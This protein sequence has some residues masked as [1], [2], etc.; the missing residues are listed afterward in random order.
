[1]PIQD[2]PH[3]YNWDNLSLTI[4]EAYQLISQQFV[5]EENG[6]RY[7]ITDIFFD[8]LS[9]QVVGRREIISPSGRAAPDPRD[10]GESFAVAY[11]RDRVQACQLPSVRRPSLNDIR[12][13]AFRLAVTEELER[14]QQFNILSASQI[15]C[16]PDEHGHYYYY[17]S[18]TEAQ[19]GL[20]QLALIIPS[21]D[22]VL[23]DA[24]LYQSHE[25]VGH[26]KRDKT[27][28]VL[29]RYVW[30]QGMSAA[31]RKYVQ[32]CPECIRRGSS[33]DRAIASFP[34]LVHGLVTHRWQRLSIDLQG[35]FPVSHSGNEYL[36]VAMDHFTK[37]AIATAIEDKDARTIADF[38]VTEIVLRF[39]AP[40]VILT[41]RGTEFCNQLNLWLC[42]ALGVHHAKTASYNPASNGQVE[43]FNQT[44]ANCL[45]KRCSDASHKDWDK[46]VAA[47]VS[48]SNICINRTTGYT[49]Y[50]L[51]YGEECRLP[52]DHSLPMTHFKGPRALDY[53]H[54]SEQLTAILS[55]AHSSTLSHQVA[56]QSLY[57]RPRKVEELPATFQQPNA[58]GSRLPRSFRQGDWVMLWC[59]HVHAGNAKKLVKMWDGPFQVQSVINP[60]S[61]RIRIM[62]RSR[63]VHVNRLKQY[64]GPLP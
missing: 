40:D 18:F 34:V 62:Q 60:V 23:Q 47:C 54:Y 51:V 28:N 42:E 56:S 16:I 52:L 29:S 38:I 55:S 44:I 5:D 36:C 30:W 13:E 22:K 46:H 24:L 21:T 25:A 50:F 64:Y 39:G 45:A 11:L 19:N 3:L 35:P 37:F 9:Q 63:I 59:P 49:P 33:T 43:R 4:P 26:H 14:L 20:E 2:M 32:A 61:Y 8:E 57:N 15:E 41:D 7:V 31:V 10:R 17:Y 1:M 58:K 6:A 27:L 53:S 12:S 48:A